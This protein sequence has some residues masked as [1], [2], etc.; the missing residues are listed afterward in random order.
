MTD[1]AVPQQLLHGHAGSNTGTRSAARQQPQ[2]SKSVE[3]ETHADCNLYLRDIVH[4]REEEQQ[5][6]RINNRV[7]LVLRKNDD[8]FTCLQFCRHPEPTFTGKHHSRVTT[9]QVQTGPPAR[10]SSEALP[11]V[12]ITLE[13]NDTVYEPQQNTFLNLRE[14]WNVETAG[15]ITFAKLGYVNVDYWE[16]VRIRAAQIFAKSLKIPWPSPTDDSHPSRQSVVTIV[17]D[18][19]STP[20]SQH[21]RFPDQGPASTMQATVQPAE[22]HRSDQRTE[23]RYIESRDFC[24]DCRSQ[25]RQSGKRGSI[26]RDQL[27]ETCQRRLRRA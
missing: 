17:Q 4:I 25:Y 13:W 6:S 27:C 3:Y 16:D 18:V 7:M 10:S 9:S 21:V 23:R 20:A 19:G 1:F 2:G 11:A 5:D 14:T 15:L 26:P 12:Q 8:S 24:D 22:P